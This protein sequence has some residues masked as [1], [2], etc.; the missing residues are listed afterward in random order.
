MPLAPSL[1]LSVAGPS[2]PPRLRTA[3]LT[4][5]S[6]RASS[7]PA[8]RQGI[9]PTRALFDSTNYILRS[10]KRGPGEEVLNPQ[11]YGPAGLTIS[12]FQHKGDRRTQE[13]RYVVVPHLEWG[14]PRQVR[15]SG[16]PSAFFGIFDGTVGDFASENAKELVIPTLLESPNWQAIPHALGVRSTDSRPSET[17]RLAESAMHDLYRSVDEGVLSR[18]ARSGKHYATCTS[19]TLCVIGDLL[20]VGHLG[21]SRIVF[22]KVVESSCGSQILVG[23]HMTTD[24]KPDDIEERDR[25]ERSGGMV[26]R[27]QN[28]G[29]KPFIRGGDFMMRK[30]LGEQ[31]MQLQY[32]RAFGGKDL[33]MF[34]LS[35]VPDVR[36]IRMGSGSYQQVRMAILASDG[37]W[38]V[39]DA[40]TAVE[41]AEEA[42]V[43][44]DNPAEELVRL[45]LLEQSRRRARAD[46]ITCICVFFD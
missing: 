6:R 13:D 34:G 14:T 27:L 24:H 16:P 17:E 38:D 19:V 8:K 2:S 9:R 46:N 11:R 1:R 4:N 39:V 25:I 35:S 5:A 42:A 44:G 12:A 18:C 37:L 20:V 26:E 23:E 15:M 10:V 21:D 28:H 43:R 22:G 3:S 32:S 45:V 7:G 33:K 29:N 40:Q 30:A 31:P 41:K 36:V